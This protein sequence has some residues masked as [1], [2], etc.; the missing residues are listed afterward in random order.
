M[1]IILHYCQFN[2][3]Y[4]VPYFISNRFN[5][6]IQ[7][8]YCIVILFVNIVNY[9]NRLIARC[10]SYC[11]L[12]IIVLIIVF[13]YCCIQ[14]VTVEF[15]IDWIALYNLIV[16]CFSLGVGIGLF[17]IVVVWVCVVKV[18]FWIV[19]L[20]AKILKFGNVCLSLYY[21]NVILISQL[22]QL[23]VIRYYHYHLMTYYT[24]HPRYPANYKIIN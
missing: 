22:L 21:H 12:F 10:Y 17:V 23:Y 2:Y 3:H 18:H 13:I 8:K 9:L 5:C 20:L 11:T 15:L 24:I 14:I 1:F 6:L 4:P 7:F 16:L 19:F